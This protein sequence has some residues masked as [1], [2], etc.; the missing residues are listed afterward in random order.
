MITE[1]GRV[2]AIEDDG[3][4]VETIR[5]STCSNCAAQKGCGHG[6]VN[7]LGSNRS[8]YIRVLFGD[9]HPDHFCVDD[10]VEITI[11]EQILVG[12]AFIVY[13]VPL[14]LMLVGAAI[15]ESL[16]SQ[17][18]DES[19]AA[20]VG[21]VS[22]FAS[23]LCIIRWHSINIRNNCEYQPRLAASPVSTVRVVN[24]L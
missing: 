12:A 1:T 22:G 5:K 14:L 19:F 2:V 24:N 10:E 21:C 6:V 7:K 11:P 15:G 3:L 20:I 13:M 8:S 17:Y 18:M 16:L 9:Q 4:W 23:G